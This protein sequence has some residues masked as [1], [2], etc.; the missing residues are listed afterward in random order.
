M[1]HLT[2]RQKTID[3]HN[4][5]YLNDIDKEKVVLLEFGSKPS[6]VSP[7]GGWMKTVRLLITVKFPVMMMVPNRIIGVIRNEVL[8]TRTTPKV[9]RPERR[10]CGLRI[11]RE[12]RKGNLRF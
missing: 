6:V 11:G 3:R 10:M 5:E 12:N 4:R 1:S 9:I 2:V 7:G 8:R